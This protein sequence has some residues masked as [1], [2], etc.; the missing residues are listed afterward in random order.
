M[1]ATL[2]NVREAGNANGKSARVERP[3]GKKNGHHE[4]IG[5]ASQ[6]GLHDGGKSCWGNVY[7]IWISTWRDGQVASRLPLE[8]SSLFVFYPI[9][10]LIFP[11]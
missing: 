10:E 8:T 9:G 11:K 4:I 1:G 5:N 2:R 7:C 6:T 3:A